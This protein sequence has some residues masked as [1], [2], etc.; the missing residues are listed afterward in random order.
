MEELN[1]RNP[2]SV[3]FWT[4]VIMI[5]SIYNIRQSIGTIY[6]YFYIIVLLLCFGHIII[7]IK[8][9]NEGIQCILWNDSHIIFEYNNKKEKINI[10]DISKIE[11]KMLKG[12][13]QL[14]MKNG[15]TIRLDLSHFNYV[16]V[17]KVIEKATKK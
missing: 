6:F 7:T 17:F 3:L 2:L 10:S 4:I 11:K 14:L 12:N 5:V 15:E 13:Y 1:K 9:S 16:L 8:K